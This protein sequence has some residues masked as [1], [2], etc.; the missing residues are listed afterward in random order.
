MSYNAE[1]EID[2]LVIRIKNLNKNYQVYNHPSDRFK[3]F[4]FPKIRRLLGLAHKS[5]SKEYAALSNVS[6]EV[7]KGETVGIIGRNGA[8]KSTLLQIICN[9]LRPSSG[10]VETSGRI[11]ALLEL[12]SG[13]NTEYTGRENVYLNA[14]V[15]GLTREEVNKRFD[16]IVEFAEIG[17]YINQPVKNYSSGMFVRLA[18]AVIVHVDAD[19]LIIDEALSVGDV[20]FQQKCMRF[21]RSFKEKGGSLLFVSHDTATVL[22]ICDHAILLSPGGLEPAIKGNAKEICD[23]YLNQL[24]AEPSRRVHVDSQRSKSIECSQST[25]ARTQVFRGLPQKANVFNVSPFREDAESFGEKGAEIVVA[26][27]IDDYGIEKESIIGGDKVIFYVRALAHQ[28]IHFPAFGI[29]L[30]DRLGQFLFTEG[31]DH[32]FRQHHLVF[33]KGDVIEASFAFQMPILIAGK[34]TINVA[35]AEGIGDEHI[36]HHWIHDAVALL[37]IEG[38]VVHGIGGLT[39]LEMQVSINPDF[40]EIK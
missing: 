22:S 37:S 29:M 10:S 12:G 24:Y 26:G 1:H 2:E 6:F 27:F 3:E 32:V 31:T 40:Q 30:K 9:T 18:F 20:Y 19:V 7:K 14:I 23:I 4:I 13:F 8:G 21:I 38:P 15:L 11:A 39:S 17:D 33:Q 5:Y 35:L 25:R 34:Y 36:Q 16:S 28:T